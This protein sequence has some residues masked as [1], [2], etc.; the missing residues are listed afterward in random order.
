[1]NEP[2]LKPE[3]NQAQYYPQ[4]PNIQVQDFKT[5]VIYSTLGLGTATGLFFLGRYIYNT[6]MENKAQKD[7]I[8]EGN[9]ATYAKQLKMAF[10]NDNWMGWGTNTKLVLQVFEQIPS[11][12]SYKKVESAYSDMYGKNLNADLESELSSNEYNLM[13]SILSSKK[14]K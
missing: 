14:L 2:I 12:T 11:K 13:I 7:S 10:D 4:E 9:P 3:Y 8:E 1:M 6:V 5:L